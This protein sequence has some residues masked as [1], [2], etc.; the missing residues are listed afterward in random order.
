MYAGVAAGTSP[1]PRIPLISS[2]TTRDAPL[3][4]QEPAIEEVEVP[5][6]RVVEIPIEKVRRHSHASAT[7]ARRQS[8][9]SLT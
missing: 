7:P 9:S 5:I 2:Q 8:S 4:R 6:E 1:P 3:Q